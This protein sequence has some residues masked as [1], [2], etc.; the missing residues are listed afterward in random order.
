MWCSSE[1][2]YGWRRGLVGCPATIVKGLPRGVESADRL[3]A[4][5][6]V[7]RTY[8]MAPIKDPNEARFA[9]IDGNEAAAYPKF[10]IWGAKLIILLCSR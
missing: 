2:R 7:E 5:H 6:E 1:L 3:M 4:H 9:T 8:F 10:V